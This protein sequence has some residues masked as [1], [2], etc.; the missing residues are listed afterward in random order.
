MRARSLAPGRALAVG[1]AL[2][3]F[4]MPAVVS[5]QD[6]DYVVDLADARGVIDA[7]ATVEVTLTS[8]ADPV[9]A[10]EF[11][12]CDDAAIDTGL[13]GIDL[14]AALEQRELDTFAIDFDTDAWSVSALLTF[15]SELTAGE[16]H[17]ILLATYELLIVGDS[18]LDFCGALLP[19]QV[20][21]LFGAEIEPETSGAIVTIRPPAPFL[22]GDADA[23]GRIEPLLDAAALFSYWSGTGDPPPCLDAADVNDN[24][25]LPPISDA[26]RLLD[27]AYGGGAPLAFPGVTTCDA[28]PAGGTL[29]CETPPD[30][31]PSE[32][33]LLEPDPMFVLGFGPALDIV[34]VGEDVV[35]PIQLSV[36]GDPI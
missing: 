6:P 25:S 10:F 26:T 12:V 7:T 4:L 29:G 17:E 35:F 18:A 19:A 31:C 20:T 5:G 9:S 8:S 2:V 16:P 21:T 24:G 32:P 36:E 11:D 28:E 27:W 15:G 30:P 1:C 14:G 23:N 34:E 22:R 33:P 3:P 13:D